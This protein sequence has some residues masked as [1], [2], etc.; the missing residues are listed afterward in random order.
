MPPEDNF[1]F[2]QLNKII[3]QAKKNPMFGIS[4]D[5]IQELTKAWVESYNT[6]RKNNRRTIAEN[7]NYPELLKLIVKHKQVKTNIGFLVYIGKYL[8]SIIG[9]EGA[10]CDEMTYEVAIVDENNKFITREY[11]SSADTFQ[12]SLHYQDLVDID[13]IIKWCESKQDN[14]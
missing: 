13:N 4:K 6:L 2:N 10:F 14:T 3:E 7:H 11:D 5:D 8:V 12:M 9:G 1:D